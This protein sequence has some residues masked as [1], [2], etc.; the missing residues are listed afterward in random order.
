MEKNVY[1]RFR[2]SVLRRGTLR[3]KWHLHLW[4]PFMFE[5]SRTWGQQRAHKLI[6]SNSFVVW[7][8]NIYVIIIQC[9]SATISIQQASDNSVGR[10]G[11]GPCQVIALFGPSFV[12]FLVLK[13][14]TI[15]IRNKIL[16]CTLKNILKNVNDFAMR[17][18]WYI[19]IVGV[20]CPGG[21]IVWTLVGIIYKSAQV[22]GLFIDIEDLTLNS[23]HTTLVF[24][25]EDK[26][27]AWPPLFSGMTEVCS[28]AVTTLYCYF[29]ASET[30][31]VL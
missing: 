14:Q 4:C 7:R 29:F 30:L 25:A 20:A 26:G 22:R 13:G 10:R 17:Q 3:A 11:Q 18:I 2:P 16:K 9:K 6:I 31:K 1:A 27:V 21:Y 8:K 28:I 24:Q 15:K 23:L 5:F 19:D 12:S